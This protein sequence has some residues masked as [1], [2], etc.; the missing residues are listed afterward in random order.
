MRKRTQ[1]ASLTEPPTSGS[2]AKK[3]TGS[4]SYSRNVPKTKTPSPANSTPPPQV[5]SRPAMSPW[6][7][8]SANSR[9]TRHPGHPSPAPICR[10]LPH[11]LRKRIPRQTVPRRRT[12][13][14]LHLQPAGRHQHPGLAERRSR[15]RRMVRPRRYLQR[16]PEIQRQILRSGRRV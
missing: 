11:L 15:I 9:R 14:R 4:R 10:N 7:P 5:I 16:M 6:N 2:S 1:K 12:G 13:L 3:T 8:Q